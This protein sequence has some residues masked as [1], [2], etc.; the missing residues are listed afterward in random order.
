MT[1]ITQF[2]YEASGTTDSGEPVSRS[3]QMQ[4]HQEINPDDYLDDGMLYSEALQTA[5]T[6]FWSFGVEK[7]GHHGLSD[8]TVSIRNLTDLSNHD[9]E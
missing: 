8:I 3:R 4:M 6:D 9:G 2:D 7:A 1:L 5:M